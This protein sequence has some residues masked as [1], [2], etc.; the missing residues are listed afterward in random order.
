MKCNPNYHSAL[1][2][3]IKLCQH[4]LEQQKTPYNQNNPVQKEQ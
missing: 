2:Q 4:Y 1:K 3:K